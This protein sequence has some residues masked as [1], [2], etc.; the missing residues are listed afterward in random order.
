MASVTINQINDEYESAEKY[1]AESVRYSELFSADDGSGHDKVKD[2]YAAKLK[3]VL[4]KAVY[5]R[6][7]MQFFRYS[8][9]GAVYVYNGY[10]FERH[11]NGV[12]YFE[13]IIKLALEYAN[14]GIVYQKDERTLSSAA[15]ICYKGLLSHKELR[16]EPDRTFVVFTNCVLNLRTGDIKQFNSRYQTDLLLDFRYVKDYRSGQWESFVRETIPG[17][18]YRESFQV[19]CGA[20]LA[21]RSVY[22]IEKTC[23]LIGNGRNGKSVLT[24]AIG[25]MLGDK[26]VSYFTPD[27]LLKSSDRKF[28]LAALPGKL[29]NFTDDVCHRDYSGGGL[30]QLIS[31][32]A[33]EARHPYGARNFKIENN[34]IPMFVFCANEYP[35]STDLS[36]GNYR[37]QF[38]V[39]CP[40][41]IPDEKVDYQLSHKLATEENKCGIFNWLYEGYRRF[42]ELGGKI[43]VAS[44]ALRIIEEMKANDDVVRRF[45]IEKNY[46]IGDTDHAT[47]NWQPFPSI[48]D[49]FKTWCECTFERPL[50]RYKFG[51]RLRELGFTTWKREPSRSWIN[52]RRDPVGMIQSGGKIKH[53]ELPF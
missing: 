18:E 20:F 10:Y 35:M 24:K 53:K 31:G 32:N 50:T 33:F 2:L 37:R 6:P 4:E 44:Q 7:G 51:M 43:P 21:D 38:P 22:S 23:F 41:I 36:D 28:N 19:Y 13:G 27:E 26:L 34:D 40:N 46:A 15:R 39:I 8:E 42:V 9:D 3:D 5:G 1:L 16:F 47:G 11:E 25:T 45:L 48:Y 12:S 14:L 49:D 29:V 52:I 17:D 30:K